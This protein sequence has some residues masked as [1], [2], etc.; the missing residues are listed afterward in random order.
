MAKAGCKDYIKL[1]IQVN[2]FLK[3]CENNFSENA[4]CEFGLRT[5]LKVLGQ[6][7]KLAKSG[8]S[9]GLAIACS[10]KLIVASKIP[11]NDDLKDMMLEFISNHEQKQFNEYYPNVVYDEYES[12]F[13]L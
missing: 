6:T 9:F 2:D 3:K 13:I 10:L 7:L 5:L 4:Q 12:K 8:N 11:P 1:G